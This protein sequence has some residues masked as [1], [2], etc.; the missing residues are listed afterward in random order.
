LGEWVALFASADG[1]YTHAAR[2]LPSGK[3]TSKLGTWE[4][5]EHDS[6]E[7]VGGGAYGELVA[8]LFRPV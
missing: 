5:I 3:W 7:A 1:N 6:V 2:Q 8:R 4:D